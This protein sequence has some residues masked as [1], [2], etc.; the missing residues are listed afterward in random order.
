MEGTSN[1][2]MAIDGATPEHQVDEDLHSRQLAVYGRESMKRMA[3]SSI[4]VS[5]LNGL[6]VEIGEERPLSVSVGG[7]GSFWREALPRFD[8][9]SELI[10]RPCLAVSRLPLAPSP[11]PQPRTSSS[12]A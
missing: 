2:P 9:R 12:Q 3:T 10:C 7:G 1:T 4:L 8:M 6:G 5:G 11:P